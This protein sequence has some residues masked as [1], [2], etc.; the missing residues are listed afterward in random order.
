MRGGGFEGAAAARAP[1]PQSRF[2]ARLLFL[3][4]ASAEGAAAGKA[5]RCWQQ[6]AEKKEVS[7]QR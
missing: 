2:P 7:F 3:S 4:P 6:E 1:A 5:K